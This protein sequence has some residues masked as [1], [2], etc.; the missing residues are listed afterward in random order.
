MM[1]KDKIFLAGAL[2]LAAALMFAACPS[3]NDD[4]GGGGPDYRNMIRAITDPVFPAIEGSSAYYVGAG[5]D[6]K[7]VFIEGR[8]VALEP[9]VMAQYE[10]TYDLWDEVRQWAISEARGANRY[11]FANQGSEGIGTVEGA[12]PTDKKYEPVTNITW[13]DAVVWC[14]AYSEKSGKDPVY[15]DVSDRVLRDSTAAVETLVDITKGAGKKGYRLPT[16]AEWEYAARGG[17]TPSTDPDN[18]F[19]Y[20]W[21]GTN[22]VDQLGNYAWSNSNSGGA[23]HQVGRKMSNRLG[24]YDMTGNVMEW[25]WDW[26]V[27][28]LG[29]VGVKGPDGGTGRVIRGGAWDSGIGLDKLDCAVAYRYSDGPTG[30]SPNVG[31]RVA[32]SF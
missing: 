32:V 27:G 25:C 29:N 3:P 2:A 16:E 26:Y 20:R 11:T 30:K 17:G 14:N 28:S 7:G 9:F 22:D 1:K 23:T 15:R 10:T 12:P 21:A 6:Y 4:S 31:F 18:P 13:R 19:V 5:D 24:L 8:S